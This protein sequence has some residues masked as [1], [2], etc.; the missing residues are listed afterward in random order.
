MQCAAGTIQP[1]PVGKGAIS[2]L[3]LYRL[4]PCNHYDLVALALMHSYGSC[5]TDDWRIWSGPI[6]D[7]CVQFRHRECC[8]T[9]QDQVGQDI[10]FNLLHRLQQYHKLISMLLEKYSDGE[11]IPPMKCKNCTTNTMS[12]I[13][14]YVSFKFSNGVSYFLWRFICAQV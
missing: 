11:T 10:V 8:W 6:L 14:N 5:M 9:R 4:I 1:Y 2:L 12:F 7:V 3:E 13:N